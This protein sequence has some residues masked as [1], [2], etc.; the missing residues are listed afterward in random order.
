VEGVVN[1][2]NPNPHNLRDGESLSLFGDPLDG[3]CRTVSLL[4]LGVIDLPRAVD[5][6]SKSKI[7]RHCTGRDQ[8]E[9]YIPAIVVA[10][11]EMEDRYDEE[12]NANDA[13]LWHCHRDGVI[14]VI[15]E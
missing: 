8:K 15:H 6:R 1:A 4:I 11:E 12:S 7:C 14:F 13:Y 2:P 9:K 5:T 10:S 3:A